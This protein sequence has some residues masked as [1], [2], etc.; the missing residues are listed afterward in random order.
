MWGWVL[1]DENALVVDVIVLMVAV[2]C[3]LLAVGNNIA[4]GV[5]HQP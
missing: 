3:A 4:K 1:V 5:I 2:R